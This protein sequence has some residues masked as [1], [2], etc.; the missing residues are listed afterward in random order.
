MIAEVGH[1]RFRITDLAARTGVGVPTVYYYFESRDQIIAESQVHNWSTRTEPTPERVQK[2]SDSIT[3]D[4]RETFM[5]V[6]HDNLAQI[7]QTRSTGAGMDAIYQMVDIWANDDAREQMSTTVRERAQYWT[8]FTAEAQRR[9]WL[10]AD[11]DP[12]LLV[13]LFW[14]AAFGQ[15]IVGIA[16]PDLDADRIASA[17]LHLITG[18]DEGGERQTT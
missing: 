2:T 4:D 17:Y 5:E 7:W 12:S 13:S 8:S 16:S 3:F 14:A 1:E 18:R 15:V 9:G 6:L 10:V 11:V